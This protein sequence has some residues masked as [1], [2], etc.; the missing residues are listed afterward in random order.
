MNPSTNT[1]IIPEQV[2]HILAEPGIQRVSF[3]YNPVF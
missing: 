2:L 3:P 1:L